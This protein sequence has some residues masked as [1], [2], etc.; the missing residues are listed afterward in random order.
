LTKDKPRLVSV[1]SG[2]FSK[3]F[4]LLTLVGLLFSAMLITAPA[5]SAHAQLVASY[6]LDGSSVET[7]PRVIVLTWEEDVRTKA[8]Q[9]SLINSTGKKIPSNFGYTFD[10]STQE[11]T[12]SLTPIAALSKGSYFLSW[13]AISHDGHLV[14]G[15]ISF[16]VK[17]PAA[18]GVNSPL[19]SY[20]EQGLQLIFWVLLILIFG[21]IFAGRMKI[22]A[23]LAWLAVFTALLRVANSYSIL[24]QSFLDTGSTKVSIAAIAILLLIIALSRSTTRKVLQKVGINPGSDLKIYLLILLSIL[25]SSQAFFEGHAL[26]LQK[27]GYLKYIS[28]L[29]LLFA[30][31]WSGSVVAFILNRTKEQ[32]AVT[33]KISTVS[34]IFIIIFGGTLTYFLV[35]PLKFANKT[36]WLTFLLIKLA[37]VLLTLGIGAF[38]HFR[39]R[40]YLEESEL[41][42]KRSLTLELLTIIGVIASTTLMVSYTPPKI[43]ANQFFISSRV[44][45]STLSDG[46]IQAPIKF[47][48]GMTGTLYI[49][50]TKAGA[51]AMIM[52]ALNSK[53]ILKARFMD[54]YLSNSSLNIVDLHVKLN[55]GTNQYMSYITVPS[56]GIWRVTLQIMIDEFTQLQSSVN[57]KI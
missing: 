54:T 47:N 15:T 46:Y 30:L 34:V 42:F 38:H 51:P 27:Q 28:A 21:A 45:A 4:T 22:F 11:G 19:T 16:G 43:V 39:G 29:H 5:A 56:S 13:K 3:I 24:Q 23:I 40:R 33:R 7:S 8:S 20:P 53:A 10:K 6:P 26:D 55:G 31:L 1:N 41:P 32:Y 35:R 17:T 25:F 50:K 12:A 44:N 18:K 36:A 49:Q 9:F 14:G 52:V 48:D 2:V 57:L 37:F